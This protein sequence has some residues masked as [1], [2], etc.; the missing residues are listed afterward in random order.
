MWVLLAWY[1]A[2]STGSVVAM[3]I[4]MGLGFELGWSLVT[5]WKLPQKIASW[6]CWQI[7]N[8][9]YLMER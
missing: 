5:D 4:V 8:G 3:G 9:R 1:V 6:Y 7:K 2:S